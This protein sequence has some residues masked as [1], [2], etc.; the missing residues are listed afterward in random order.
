MAEK[1]GAKNIRAFIQLRIIKA[2]HADQ[3][4]LTNV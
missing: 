1:A 2:S 3:I 4:T